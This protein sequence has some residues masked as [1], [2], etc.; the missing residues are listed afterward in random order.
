M[1]QALICNWTRE[2]AEFTNL[3][4]DKLGITRDIIT[5]DMMIEDNAGTQFLLTSKDK[6]FRYPIDCMNSPFNDWILFDPFNNKNIMKFL[7]DLYIDMNSDEDGPSMMGYYKVF[8]PHGDP[9]SQLHMIL[10]DRT[11]YTT[12][13]YINVSL[14]YMELIDFLMFGEARYDYTYLE[15]FFWRDTKNDSTKQGPRKRNK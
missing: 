3:I 7:F 1:E 14:Q 13:P 5:G 8:L 10:T 2:I 6:F 4:C 15:R 9:R 11:E 12:R